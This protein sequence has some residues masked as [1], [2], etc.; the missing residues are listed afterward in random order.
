MGENPGTNPD[1]CAARTIDW[2]DLK[3][4]FIVGA[5]CAL[6]KLI[7]FAK[8]EWHLNGVD[9]LAAFLLTLGYIIARGRWQPDKLDEWGITTPLT[10]SAAAAG[11]LLLGI[12]IGTLAAYGILLTGRLDFEPSYVPRMVEYIVGAF[13]QQFVMCSVGLVFLAKFRVF[14][15][16]WRLPLAVGLVFSLA[17]FWTPAHIPG[18]IVPVQMVLVLPAGFVCA[19]Y[20]LNFRSILPLTGIHAITYVLM[21]NW[22]EAHL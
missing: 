19:F 18:T 2:M 14:R 21:H 22:V 3:F 5:V 12:A 16:M 13:P 10:L 15:G 17:H 6:L 1:T 7:G 4:A 20:F 8:P 9:A 11:L